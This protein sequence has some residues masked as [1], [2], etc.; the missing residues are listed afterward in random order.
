MPEVYGAELAQIRNTIPMAVNPNATAASGSS[1]SI[2]AR[3]E[4]GFIK[5][6]RADAEPR[7]Q[8]FV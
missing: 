2:A 4:A 7:Q 3:S 5:F 1:M 6:R 8:L